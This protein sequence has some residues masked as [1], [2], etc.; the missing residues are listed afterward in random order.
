MHCERTYYILKWKIQYSCDL[1][2]DS[3]Y[4]LLVLCLIIP[5]II[6]VIYC[7]KRFL[8]QPFSKKRNQSFNIIEQ[9][10]L[11]SKER[12][13]CIELNGTNLLLGVT[14]TTISTLHVFTDNSPKDFP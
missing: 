13:V 6:G 5:L 10:S 14:P 11:G 3:L 1:M 7:L 8:T 2:K 4:A 9:L 12:L